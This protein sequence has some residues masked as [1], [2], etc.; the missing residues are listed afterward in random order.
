M[1]Q[2]ANATVNI[3]DVNTNAGFNVAYNNANAVNTTYKIINTDYTS[4]AVVCGYTSS[5]ASTSFGSILTRSQNPNN[6][7]VGTVVNNTALVLANFN[8]SLVTSVPQQK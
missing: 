4:Y 1:N 8:S 6:T 7:L 3:T 2:Q 5:N